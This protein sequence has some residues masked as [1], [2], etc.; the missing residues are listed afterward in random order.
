[1][2]IV[3]HRADVILWVL[4]FLGLVAFAFSGAI[5][6]LKRK[7]DI[8]GMIIL[9]LVASICGGITRDILIG[10]LPPEIMHSYLPLIIA[11]STGL[12][13][14]FFSNH[15]HKYA[16]PI[17]FFDAIGLG[18]FTVVGADK[19]LAFGIDPIWSIGLGSVTGV[20]GG[21][22]RDVLLARV[23]NILRKEIYFTPAI[24]G[25]SIVVIGKSLFAIESSLFM[26]LGAIICTGVRL[27]T[28]RYGWHMPR[29]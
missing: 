19:A 20:G 23:P 9:S 16:Y 26:I 3:V 13:T 27:F 2:D 6:A 22:I 14:F 12:I 8:V 21:V 18:L 24:L 25:A 5:A 17:D 28:L 1:M 11:L 29:R 7:T 15:I 10:D 4:N